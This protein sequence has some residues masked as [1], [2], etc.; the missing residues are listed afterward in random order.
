MM[1]VPSAPSRR[2]SGGFAGW[3]ARSPASG[4]PVS[5]CAFSGAR[6]AGC[7]SDGGQPESRGTAGFMAPETHDAQHRQ[8]ITGTDGIGLRMPRR[9]R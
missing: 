2:G 3:P 8:C 4:H 1:A 6:Q 7:I 5:I 9:P